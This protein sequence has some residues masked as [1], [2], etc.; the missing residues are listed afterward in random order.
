MLYMRSN[1]LFMK[2]NRVGGNII[3]IQGRVCLR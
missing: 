3:R 1:D 2:Q